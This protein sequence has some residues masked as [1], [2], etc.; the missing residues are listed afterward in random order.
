VV[1]L[2]Q[3][4]PNGIAWIPNL[5]KTIAE[6]AMNGCKSISVDKK[7]IEGPNPNEKGKSYI[8]LILAFQV[9]FKYRILWSNPSFLSFG[10]EY[11]YCNIP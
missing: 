1:V 11:V 8:P 3:V 4:L 9:S 2:R 6:V 5:V 10:Q 7:L